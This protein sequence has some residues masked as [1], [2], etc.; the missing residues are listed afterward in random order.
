MSRFGRLLLRQLFGNPK[1]PTPHRLVSLLGLT[2]LLT[3]LPAAA[4]TREARLQEI[5]DAFQAVNVAAPGVVVYA[6]SPQ[7]D[8][9]W[10]GTTGLSNRNGAPL[11]GDAT[12]R[13]ASNT[14]TYVAAAVLRLM[15]EGKLSLDDSLAD[16]LPPAWAD[17]LRADGYRIG[18]MTLRMV[19]SHTSGLWEH[20]A[21]P[22]YGEAIEANPQRVWTPDEVVRL[23]VEWG[24]PVGPPGAQWSYSDTGYI[25]LGRIIE[26]LTGQPLGV[27]VRR[28]VNYDKL[29]LKATWWEISE[30]APAATGDRAHQYYG[31]SDT[32]D[33]NPSLDLYGGGGI[34]CDAKD[35]GLFT[36]KL[37]KGR[38][39]AKP[40]TL[41]LM[42]GEGAPN[43]RLGLMNVELGPYL[44]WG[45][46]GFWNTFS[47]YVPSLDLTLSGCVLNHFAGRGQALAAQMV[48]ALSE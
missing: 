11:T 4:Q 5:L 3:A 43:Y 46:T 22:R 7:L 2:L 19:L 28:L 48:E 27:A 21:D 31:D 17:L 26:D 38:V 37:M 42:I 40:A 8:L 41:G 24:D 34:I 35:L 39:F 16:H 15:E 13:I 14:K 9:D 18:D 23:T 44:G 36:R 33:W 29:G 25:L 45:H 20:P 47:F 32:H 10:T 12:F 6:Y 30:T 1:G